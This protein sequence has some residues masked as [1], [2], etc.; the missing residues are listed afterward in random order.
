MLHQ[1]FIQAPNQKFNSCKGET[2]NVLC[3]STCMCHKWCKS[4]ADSQISKEI[5]SKRMTSLPFAIPFLMKN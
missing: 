3:Q 2:S 1:A 4:D 5:A